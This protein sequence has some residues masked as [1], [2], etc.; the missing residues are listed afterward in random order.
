MNEAAYMPQALDDG[1]GN[2]Q[3]GA[4]TPDSLVTNCT[5]R[6]RDMRAELRER[7]AKPG[8]QARNL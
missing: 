3:F 1:R 8:F 5:P 2:G 7:T 6:A 4:G